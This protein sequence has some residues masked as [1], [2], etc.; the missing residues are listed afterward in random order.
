MRVGVKNAHV[1]FLSPAARHA[2]LLSW[3]YLDLWNG[4]GQLDPD[5]KA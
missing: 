4:K 5:Q 3:N 1:I 2:H